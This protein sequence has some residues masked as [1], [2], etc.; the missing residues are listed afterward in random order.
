[1]Q[2][3]RRLW[4]ITRLV[5]NT[6]SRFIK[7]DQKVFA[8]VPEDWYHITLLNRTHFEESK[9]IESLTAAEQKEA[10]GIIHQQIKAPVVLNANGLLLTR[11]GALIVPA[12]P[13]DNQIYDL[14][15]TIVKEIPTLGVHVPAGAHI[16]IGNILRNI[17][18][19]K[20]SQLLH[21]IFICGNHISD[22]LE[23]KDI[24]SPLG[25]IRLD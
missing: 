25:T 13:F 21:A 23:F 19:D 4:K 10:A 24:Y 14:R 3:K 17:D 15:S 8:Y 2:F 22:R 20:L 16:K 12:F 7:E 9:E 18:K 1:M 6:F 11:S 5:E